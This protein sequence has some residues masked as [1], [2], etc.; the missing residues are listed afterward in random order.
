MPTKHTV[1]PIAVA[2]VGTGLVGG[3]FVRQLLS[4]PQ[5]SPYLLVS[6]TTLGKTLFSPT[7]LALTP[8]TWKAQ[9]NAST[10]EPRL[11]SLFEKLAPFERAVV[12]D[13]TAAQDMAELYP[14]FLRRGVHVITPNKKAFSG[15]QGLYDAIVA[16]S[17]ESGARWLNE[18]TVGAGLPVV[19]TLKD[20]VASGD[21]VRIL[22][23]SRGTSGR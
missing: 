20:M 2:V 10:T 1:P 12:V 9:L 3:E 4:L 13:N 11:T 14:E 8:S 17:A 21:Q 22:S 6:L 23:L 7:G 15:E 18:S 19:Q 16:A 5:P